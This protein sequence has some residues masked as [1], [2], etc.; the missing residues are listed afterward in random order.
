MK[1]RC[2]PVPK[3]ALISRWLSGDYAD[4]FEA[5]LI[6]VG[7]D[8]FPCR[9]AVSPGSDNRYAAADVTGYRP[10]KKTLIPF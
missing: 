3:G 1:I 7:K 6:G 10:P 9:P 8:L 2:C 5:P 4:A